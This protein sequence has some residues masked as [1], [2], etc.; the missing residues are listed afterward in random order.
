MRNRKDE[1]FNIYLLIYIYI[2]KASREGLNSTKFSP[3][4]KLIH[5]VDYFCI[6]L[7]FNTF[8]VTI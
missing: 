6:T 7:L 5:I 4:F 1:I 8:N 3:S 2:Y